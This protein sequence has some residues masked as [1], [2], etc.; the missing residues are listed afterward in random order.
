MTNEERQSLLSRHKST[1]KDK[2]FK[3]FASYG[4]TQEMILQAIGR[5]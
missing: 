5:E 3:D 4:I 2:V 1:V